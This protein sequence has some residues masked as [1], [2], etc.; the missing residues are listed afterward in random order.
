[1]QARS[2]LRGLVALMLIV[3]A[4]LLAASVLHLSGHVTGRGAPFDA[5]HAG[6]AEAILCAVLLAGAVGMLRLPRR[7]KAIGLIA[8]GV[9]TFGFLV[10]LTMTSRGGH[11]P[12]IAYH[13]TVLPLLIG[14]LVV[15]STKELP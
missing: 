15:L 12:D 10:G 9:T 7:A 1:M 14:G 3:A 13:L 8:N 2:T 5:E 6:I 11:W 4:S